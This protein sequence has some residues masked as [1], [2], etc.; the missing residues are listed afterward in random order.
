[1]SPNLAMSSSL[2][3]SSSLDRLIKQTPGWILLSKVLRM[4]AVLSTMTA[5]KKMWTGMMAQTGH[6]INRRV[7]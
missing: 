3:M 1:M 7:G 6:Q 4:N 5:S 2:V